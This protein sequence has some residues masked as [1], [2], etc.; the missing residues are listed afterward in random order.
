MFKRLENLV[1][2]EGDGGA[3]GGGSAT[4]FSQSDVDTAVRA[5][6]DK[7]V[8]DV[9]GLKDKNTELLDKLHTSD[10]K[11]AKI[12]GMSPDDVDDYKRYKT[13]KAELEKR[14]QLDQGKWEELEKQLI[15]KNKEETE[16][17]DKRI[18]HLYKQMGKNLIDAD[19]VKSLAKW[20]GQPHLI[21]HELKNNV[22]IFENE[23][24][25][26]FTAEVIDPK[27]GQVKIADNEGTHMTIDQLVESFHKKAEWAGAFTGTTQ[28]GSGTTP[29]GQGTNVLGV[30][31]MTQ[32]QFANLPLD[33]MEIARD[34]K[35]K[36]ELKILP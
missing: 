9:K 8:G 34:R 29:G 1:K 6:V 22:K 14:K 33:Q 16:K 25:G 11:S 2:F 26:E 28:S 23:I 4:A 13:E 3:G 5:A 19:L 30:K 10:E 21:L 7:A 20:G 24:T 36:G 12:E 18:A 27:T 35:K 15:A 17:K 31:T 32:D